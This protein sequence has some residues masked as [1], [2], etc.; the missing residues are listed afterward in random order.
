MQPEL[1][2]FSQMRKNKQPRQQKPVANVTP[3]LHLPPQV[4]LLIGQTATVS[5]RVHTALVAIEVSPL[6]AQIRPGS[7]ASEP[8][9]TVK[10][11][12]VPSHTQTERSGQGS[13]TSSGKCL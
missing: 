2:Y 4:G 3:T 1:K 13:T 9:Q 12:L 6:T 8:P 11:A 7:C 10:E 5:C